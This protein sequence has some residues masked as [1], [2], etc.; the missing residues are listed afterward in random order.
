MKVFLVGYRVGWQTYGFTAYDVVKETPK[1]YKVANPICILGNDP[2][3]ST[4][5]KESINVFTDFDTAWE[6]MRAYLT[7]AITSSQARIAQ[8]QNNVSYLD[9]LTVD[10]WEALFNVPRSQ[11]K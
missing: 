1:Q 11:P 6:R 9:K 5:N 4:L 7:N 10:N 8:M 2:R 3:M